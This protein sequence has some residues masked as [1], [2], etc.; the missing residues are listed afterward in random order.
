[1]TTNTPS[2]TEIRSELEAEL[3][4]FDHEI[5]GLKLDEYKE[6]YEDYGGDGFA[7]WVCAAKEFDVRIESDYDLSTGAPDTDTTEN[8]DSDSFSGTDRYTIEDIKNDEVGEQ[9]D[10]NLEGYVVSSWKSISSNDNEM[11]NMVLRDETGTIRVMVTGS[12]ACSKFDRSGPSQ[13]EYTQL[14]QATVWVPDSNDAH[15]VMMGQYGSYASV[16]PEFD[17]EDI[18]TPFDKNTT[19]EGDFVMIDGIVTDHSSNT[20]D[21]CEF[22]KSSKFEEGMNLCPNC[23]HTTRTTYSFDRVNVKAD[24]DPVSIMFPPGYTFQPPGDDAMFAQLTAYGEWTVEEPEEED[25]WESKHI[26]VDVHD[27]PEADEEDFDMPD[28]ESAVPDTPDVPDT[29]DTE[30]T[31]SSDTTERTTSTDSTDSTESTGV[32]ADMEA[33]VLDSVEFLSSKSTKSSGTGSLCM[34]ILERSENF[35]GPGEVKNTIS[36]LIEAGKIECIDDEY[37]LVED[38]TN[39]QES[40]ESTDSTDIEYDDDIIEMAEE[41][42]GRAEDFPDE[43]PAISQVRIIRNKYGETDTDRITA[44]IECVSERENVSVRVGDDS[45]IANQ[46]WNDV[47]LQS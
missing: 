28:P 4:D 2:V 1:M 15:Y 27:F 18:A 32:T 11:R 8:D 41:I 42:E 7:A 38:T 3:D 33:D 16:V 13:G 39:T 35:D 37:H 46:D 23:E 10:F 40:T 5:F 43:L 22:C 47:Y 19:E 24:A 12:K 31:S 36:V 45:S 14:K 25:G 6:K 44:T 17:L 9:E 34:R 30:E 29:D 20:Y 26:E 21:G